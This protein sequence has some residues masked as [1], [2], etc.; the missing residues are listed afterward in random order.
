MRTF[1]RSILVVIFNAGCALQAPRPPALDLPTAFERAAPGASA[2]WPSSDWYHSFA[3]SELDALVADAVVARATLFPSLTLTASGG[4]QNPAVNA[5]I[6]S[7]SGVGPTLN[8]G[9]APMTG[10]FPF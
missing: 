6:I 2:N 9:A 8:L 1:A 3:S 7:L 5:A 10:S 4:V